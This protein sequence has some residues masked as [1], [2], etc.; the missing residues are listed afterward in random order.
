MKRALW[1][2]DWSIGQM[3]A[4]QRGVRRCGKS[5]IQAIA[6]DV[7][8]KNLVQ[9]ATMLHFFECRRGLGTMRSW[10]VE[11]DGDE[12]E[13]HDDEDEIDLTHESSDDGSSDDADPLES[14][15]DHDQSAGASRKDHENDLT[16]PIQMASRDSLV[17]QDR[18]LHAAVNRLCDAGSKRIEAF[19]RVALGACYL[20]EGS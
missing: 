10:P 16:D 5:N 9:T 20:D 1:T 12:S 11:E 7:T 13:A 6:A 4:L 3:A 19:N 15:T 14:D 17:E 18:K 2:S 8:G